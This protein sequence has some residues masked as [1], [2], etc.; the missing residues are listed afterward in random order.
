MMIRHCSSVSLG[1]SATFF[2]AYAR[3]DSLVIESSRCQDGLSDD[4]GRVV[5]LPLSDNSHDVLGSPLE[6]GASTVRAVL[7][8]DHP[9]GLIVFQLILHRV[10]AAQ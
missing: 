7:D 9:G 10:N 8:E 5:P 3:R 1:I 4:A 6:T 2:S